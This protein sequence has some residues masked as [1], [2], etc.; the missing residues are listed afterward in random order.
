MSDEIR[1]RFIEDG[2]FIVFEDG[3]IFKKLDPPVSSSGYKFVRVGKKSYPL[4]RVV[5]SAFVPNPGNK[6]EVNHIDGNKTNNAV[7]NLEWV[8]SQEN[9]RHAIETGLR[10]PKPRS[11]R[12]VPL[13]PATN[14]GRNDMKL[15]GDRIRV[16]RAMRGLKQKDIAIALGLDQTT[17]SA[18]ENGKAEPTLFNLRRLADILG[19][20][21]GD[22]F[23][24][25]WRTPFPYLAGESRPRAVLYGLEMCGWAGEVS[26]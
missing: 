1:Y 13:K 14:L 16:Y 23:P 19:V 12:L 18:W 2:D 7:S 17:V 15:M 8:T 20:T 5:A 22:L 6:P 24:E 11:V 26:P 9:M 25:D 21:P 4:H 3:R 10:K